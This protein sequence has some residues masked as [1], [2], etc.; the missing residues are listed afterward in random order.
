MEGTRSLWLDSLTSRQGVPKDE[1]DD[2]D[3]A[4]D[5]CTGCQCLMA[6]VMRLGAFGELLGLQW[7][8]VPVRG[9]WSMAMAERIRR[10]RM[11]GG[12]GERDSF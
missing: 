9:S 5:C 2:K 10:W 12:R 8:T 3:R 1:L 6:S 11:D 4:S 7:S